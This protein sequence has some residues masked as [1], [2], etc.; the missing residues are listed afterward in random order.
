[1]VVLGGRVEWGDPLMPGGRVDMGAMLEQTRHQ[2][3]SSMPSGFMQ[4]GPPEI[5][6]NINLHFPELQKFLGQLYVVFI[7]TALEKRHAEVISNL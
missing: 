7:T 1:M 2:V 4:G 6:S 3:R 5:V